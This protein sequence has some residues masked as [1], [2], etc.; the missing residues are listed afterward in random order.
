MIPPVAEPQGAVDRVTMVSPEIV[1]L[2]TAT[3]VVTLP[4]L[5]HTE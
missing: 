4:A 3:L 1:P 5:S 2:I